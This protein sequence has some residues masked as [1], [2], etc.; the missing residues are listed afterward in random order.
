MSPPSRKHAT[1]ADIVLRLRRAE[2]HIRAIVGM[3]EQG[4]PCLDLA[5]QLLAVEKAIVEAKRTLIHDHIDHCLDEVDGA[6]AAARLEDFRL[7]T[8]YL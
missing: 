6:E 1:H 5:Q 2:G 3:I 7:I 4:R 8:R